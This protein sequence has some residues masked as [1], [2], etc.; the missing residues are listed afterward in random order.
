MMAI[1]NGNMRRNFW[2]TWDTKDNAEGRE[3]N[4]TA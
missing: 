2:G 4:A 3:G 1:D